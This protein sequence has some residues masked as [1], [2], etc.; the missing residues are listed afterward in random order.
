MVSNPDALTL[1]SIL[2]YLP[3]GIRPENL[4]SVAP[5]I[6]YVNAAK[7]TLLRTAL[8]HCMPDGTLQMLSPIRLYIRQ[9]HP[10]DT[11]NIL[12]LWIFYCQVAKEGIRM[13]LRLL[14]PEESNFLFVTINAG[15]ATTI[16]D[17]GLQVETKLSIKNTSLSM[18][19][20][21]ALFNA[22]SCDSCNS[23]YLFTG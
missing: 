12:A 19:E 5:T 4:Q 3:G 10:P 16:L 17:M 15:E 22:N 6:Q 20:V 7:R 14:S 13:D 1:L 8:A 11:D 2:A 9:N 23:I 21:H 18:C